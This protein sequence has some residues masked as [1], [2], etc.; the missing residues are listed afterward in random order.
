[1]TAICICTNTL[2][3]ECVSSSAEEYCSRAAHQ[4][5]R[6]GTIDIKVQDIKLYDNASAATGL[7][8]GIL[9]AHRLGTTGARI[10]AGAT[11]VAGTDA[12]GDTYTVSS[13]SVKGFSDAQI[14]KQIAVVE[15]A[16]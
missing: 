4:V 11:V 13:M 16:L 9:D 10:A 7:T 2:V 14:T 12:A 3:L 1:M 15:A 6:P 8:D 5:Q